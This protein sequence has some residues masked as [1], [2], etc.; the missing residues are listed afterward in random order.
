MRQG[1]RLQNY[2]GAERAEIAAVPPL[3]RACGFRL[4]PSLEPPL[5][6]GHF[7]R[8]RGK[9]IPSSSRALTLALSRGAG[10]G[11]CPTVSP[12]FAMVSPSG[13]GDLLV[14]RTE[15]LRLGNCLG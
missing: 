4:S 15:C 6:F 5:S 10:E 7:P 14:G 3:G 13:R 9:P 8:E 2:F 11:I 12:G 1:R